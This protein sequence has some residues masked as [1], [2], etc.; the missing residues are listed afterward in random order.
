MNS[1][2]LL[3][4]AAAAGVSFQPNPPEPRLLATL[5][6]AVPTPADDKSYPALLE[7][8][9]LPVRFDGP[10][11]RAPQDC[12]DDRARLLGQWPFLSLRRQLLGR[13]LDAL[14]TYRHFL[15]ERFAG[16]D[17]S[18]SGEILIQDY[19]VQ[20][21]AFNLGDRAGALRAVCRDARLTRRLLLSPGPLTEG[22]LARGLLERQLTL[23]AEMRA[24]LPATQPLPEEC[25][26]LWAPARA[27][28]S[29]CPRLAHDGLDFVRL[30]DGDFKRWQAPGSLASPPPSLVDSR[31]LEIR[32]RA[33][34]A[35]YL[36]EAARHCG[37]AAAALV[38]A[39]RLDRPPRPG[40]YCWP[41]D[42]LCALED[43]RWQPF[44]AR[45]LNGGRLLTGWEALTHPDRPLP[46]GY[47]WEN[48]QLH[49]A[50][51][52]EGKKP[53]R[54]IHWPRPGQR[55]APALALFNRLERLAVD[56]GDFARAA[57]LWRARAWAGAPV[58]QQN[59]AELQR[60]GLGVAENK[61][62][63][64]RWLTA[65]ARL[66]GDAAHK[67]GELY[68]AGEYGPSDPEKA[69]LWWQRGAEAGDANAQNSLGA[70]HYHGWGVARD[71]AEA[72]RW[73]EQAA[74]RGNAEAPFNL[75]VLYE[76]GEGIP[77]SYEQ[78]FHW[79]KRAAEAGLAVAQH[80][81]GAYYARGRGVAQDYE[82]ARHWYER[83]AEGGNAEAQFNLAILYEN[84][85][86]GPRDYEKARHYYEQAAAADNVN[87][88]NN[89][90]VLHYHG[91]GVPQS[92]DE[93]KRW[94]LRAAEG[95]NVE[96]QN[97][98]AYLYAAGA[99]V[100]QD[101]AEA[102][103]WY[104]RA[105]AQ[106][107]AGAQS[108]LGELYEEGWGGA[109]DDEKARHWYERAAEGGNVEAQNHLARFYFE[110]SGGAQSYTEAQRWWQRAAEQGNVEAKLNLGTLYEK[111]WGVAQDFAEAKRWWE[112]AAEAG[113]ADGL[114]NLGTL[115]AEGRGVAQD[116]QTAR[117]YFELAALDNHPEAEFNL[118]LIAHR[119]LGQPR[120]DGA[121]RRWWQKA[122]A[123]DLGRAQVALAGLLGRGLGGPRD[124]ERAHHWLEQAEAQAAQEEDLWWRVKMMRW[125]LE[126]LER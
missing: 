96:A 27:E 11:R 13:P 72:K 63:A 56:R 2:I 43:G 31:L 14:Q 59:L 53:A 115:Y 79:Y 33:T 82:K 9:A 110:G 69:R 86:G 78:A 47:R 98:L 36:Q 104:E 66:D 49:F 81:V 95:G 41:D 94:W 35:E 37:S 100:K 77:Q 117:H 80:N 3:L 114:F 15:P 121:A 8:R 83:A 7:T 1:L 4:T 5:M 64:R 105:A 45:L 111:G 125:A 101:Y 99:G 19:A 65:A 62:Q 32:Q 106:G 107:H 24:R 109:P 91:Q 89:L 120:D 93:A 25:A 39:D 112:Q 23:L 48:G 76:N 103:R 18:F 71:F 55:L 21:L 124:R 88:Q 16:L 113:S 38:A 123:Q 85:E 34:I 70:L 28:L 22:A 10:C 61:E 67:L 68:F 6:A 40:S 17:R 60:W 74:E 26:E 12:L 102:R 57:R 84:G 44:Q 118:G 29:I 122:A 108:S 126:L 46:P 51:H 92:Y 116:W 52:P 30:Y 119:G 73:W 75:G 97:N 42:E 54:E 90:G 87:A 50:L 20:A 58:A